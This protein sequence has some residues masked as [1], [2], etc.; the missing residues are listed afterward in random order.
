M[1]ERH[2]YIVGRRKP[3]WGDGVIVVVV[4]DVGVDVERSKI[5]VAEAVVTA[6]ILCVSHYAQLLVAAVAGD[7]Y[8]WGAEEGK[9]RVM[10]HALVRHCVQVRCSGG[11][12]A[13]AAAV[14]VAAAA[15]VVEG[16]TQH[17]L[18]EGSSAVLHNPHHHRHFLHTL[19]P[20]HNSP[21]TLRHHN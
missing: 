7:E 14:I 8:F 2:L 13:A 10:C 21:H 17:Y 16:H 1:L 11:S 18:Q 4:F 3:L 20:H 5:V 9:L 12:A 19:L 15:A 6:D